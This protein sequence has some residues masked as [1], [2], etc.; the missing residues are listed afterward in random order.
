MVGITD[1]DSFCEKAPVPLCSLIGPDSGI[2]GL[3]GILPNCYAR[4]IDV[5]NTIIFQGAS[6]FAHIAALGTI[7][8]M[9]LHV[10][11]KFTAV[12]E[13]FLF[14]LLYFGNFF[15]SSWKLTRKKQK[16]R[17]SRDYHI[18][19]PFPG[20]YCVLPCRRFRCR[21]SRQW[22][23]AIFCRCADG[24]R[25]GYVH[26]SAHQRLCWIPTIWRRNGPFSV[27]ITS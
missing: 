27:A 21:S 26:M 11:S 4:N 13:W 22:S 16:R 20:A 24:S 14:V 9:I 7:V 2:T 15:R 6:D 23:M 8:V 19:L 17:P 3:P 25:L 18:L 10:R 1:I 5:G 12:G